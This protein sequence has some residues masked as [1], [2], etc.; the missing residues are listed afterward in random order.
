M[1]KGNFTIQGRGIVTLNANELKE[2]RA[3]RGGSVPAFPFSHESEIEFSGDFAAAKQMWKDSQGV[4]QTSIVCKTLARKAGA[5]DD[6]W[7]PVTLGAFYRFDEDEFNKAPEGT[8]DPRQLPT[9]G[10]LAEFLAK[11]TFTAYVAEV[12][13]KNRE[14]EE[15]T[16]KHVYLTPAGSKPST[17]GGKNK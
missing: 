12:T 14:D 16:Q 15:Y 1:K 5:G 2:A 13:R 10:E 9:Y 7:M 3:S 17:K 11:G 8:L 4:E 6:A